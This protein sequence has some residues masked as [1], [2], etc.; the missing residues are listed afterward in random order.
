MFGQTWTITLDGTEH[1]GIT[2]V[3]LLSSLPTGSTSLHLIRE[4]NAPDGRTILRG[5]PG[6]LRE[7]YRQCQAAGIDCRE[8]SVD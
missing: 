8:G 3:S 4:V 6:H 2:E 1:Q 7:L 5:D